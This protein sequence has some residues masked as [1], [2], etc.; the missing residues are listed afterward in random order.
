MLGALAEIRGDDD[1]A[2]DRY[3]EVVALPIPPNTNSPNALLEARAV[4]LSGDHLRAYELLRRFVDQELQA[5][6][7]SGASL[8]SLE[9]VNMAVATGRLEDAGRLV[10]YL[11][12]SGI[13]DV[14]GRGFR[15]LVEDSVAAVDADPAAARARADVAS[16]AEVTAEW[17]L[18]TIR[19]EL[20]RLLDSGSTTAR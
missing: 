12:R 15:L 5:S 17:A 11:D 7:V 18:R 19:D 1:L 10:G 9:F 13:L 20:G 4:F 8:A 6:N 14:E 2:R 16:N 3:D